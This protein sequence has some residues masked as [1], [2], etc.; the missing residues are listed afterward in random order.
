MILTVHTQKETNELG[1]LYG[2]FFEDL[3]HAADGGLYAELVQNRS[4]EFDPIDNPAYNGLTAWEATGG[5]VLAVRKGGAV[6]EKN[7]HYLE[8]TAAGQEE[9]G[10]QNLGFNDGIPLWKG[11][12]YY[13][14]CY[15]RGDAAG[16]RVSLRSK[17]GA[18][19]QE[20]SFPLTSCWEKYET[21]F[22]APVDDWT[23][24]LAVTVEGGGKVHLDFVSLFPQDTYKGRRNGLR[25]DLAEAL[26]AMHPKFLRFPG[27]CLVH[28][29]ALDPD[30]R[31]SQYRWKNSIGPV[32][33]RPARRNNWRYNQT[34]GLGFYE[35]FQFCEDIGAKPVPVLPGGY[36][37]HSGDAA[38]GA[39]LEAFVQD[40]LDL[41]EF[42]NGGTD[43]PWGTKRAELGHPAPFGL[44]YISIGNEEVGQPFYDRYPL[45]YRAIKEKYPDMKVIGTSGPF[46]S[47]PDY[48]RGWRSARI[49]GAELVDEH[50]Y[51]SPEWFIANHHRYDNFPKGPKVFLGEYASKGNTWYNALVE[52]SF[53][54]G[55]ERNARS[56][57]LACYAPL[58]CNVDYCNWQPDM[59]WFDNH[60][61][62]Y[63]PSYYV[64]KLFME[65]QGD[66]LLEQE[67][68]DCGGPAKLCP[69]ADS[70]T[71]GLALS[72]NES[73]VE[74]SDI[75]LINLD[76]GEQRRLPG[77]VVCEG[78]E[79]KALGQVEWTNYAVT[80]QAKE[81]E[82]RKGFH[83]YFAWQDQD[84]TCLWQ[85]GGWNN[86]YSIFSEIISGR[87]SSL[88][89][90]QRKVEKG[91]V[92]S[93]E[94]RVQQRHVF[95]YVDGEKELETEILPVLAEPLYAV[96]SRD[97]RTGDVILKLVNI[98]P[99]S[100]SL[101]VELDGTASTTG[102]A[103]L[104][105]GYALDAQNVLGEPETIAPREE[106]VSFEGNVFQWTVPPESVCIF[107]LRGT[108]II[109][110]EHT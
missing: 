40:A 2:L 36:N 51:Q 38:E 60:Q 91:R 47:G 22:T 83:I 85:L 71:G 103:Y 86:D 43:T 75:V 70:L 96:S 3:N 74:F 61:I 1:D 93:L 84:N 50:Y 21:V 42:A 99:Q 88:T 33:H 48:D 105:G 66:V 110:E 107:R 24:R 109:K 45:F 67:L 108:H 87:N 25:K 80:L 5:A 56:V 55:L 13:F 57:G 27:G 69:F 30:A 90:R 79:I 53:M 17:E 54:V 8:I 20:K 95:A 7:P 46:C 19:Y 77:P 37:P 65:H 26:E 72:G 31:N 97:R 29:G 10:V 52:A 62:M 59:I 4:F 18:V 11:A 73:T 76:T 16:I 102:I 15:A 58:F 104:M 81:L 101:T 14:A 12:G 49:D 78:A 9:A 39:A 100:Q 34:L 82:G 89:Q 28:D 35:Y 6:S 32:E 64:Q 94:L 44:E 106:T 23:A 63:T 98:L 68:R 92:Y 41:I